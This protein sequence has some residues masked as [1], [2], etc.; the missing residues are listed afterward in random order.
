MN[1][2]S[3]FLVRMALAVIAG[4]LLVVSLRL[5]LWQM[6]MEA[7]QYRGPEALKVIVRPGSLEGNLS[8]IK[9][10]NQYIGVTIPDTLP[11]TRWLPVML[12]LG[13]CLGIVAVA[14]PLRGRRIGALA[15]AALIAGALIVAAAQ[16]QW[17]MYHIGHE[18]NRH[19]ALEGIQDFT[20]PLLGSRKLAQFELTSSLG[21]GS[22]CISAAV[23]FYMATG[24]IAF[25]QARS[26]NRAQLSVQSEPHP[27]DEVEATL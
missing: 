1:S 3:R 27:S 2:K 18:R 5:P 7:P 17:Q 4:S 25:K 22:L 8:E 23:A 16:A 13:A 9:I 14:L 15:V 11:Q 20:P 26:T 6:R 19:A 21:L 10:L 24:L 12:W